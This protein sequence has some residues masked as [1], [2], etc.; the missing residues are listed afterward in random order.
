MAPANYW[1]VENRK[2]KDRKTKYEVPGLKGLGIVLLHVMKPD[3][4]NI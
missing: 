4:L 3:Y 1:N 2:N